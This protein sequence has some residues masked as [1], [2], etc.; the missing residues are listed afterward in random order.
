MRS[1]R[2]NGRPDSRSQQSARIWALG[3]DLRD[4][5]HFRT[6]AVRPVT[7]SSHPNGLSRWMGSPKSWCPS[8]L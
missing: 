5:R 6:E 3:C 8:A 4:R 7:T 1:S 2:Q